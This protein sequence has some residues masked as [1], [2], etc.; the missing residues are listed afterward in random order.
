MGINK[1]NAMQKRMDIVHSTSEPAQSATPYTANGQPL[2]SNGLRYGWDALGRLSS[3]TIQS[4]SAQ[5]QPATQA[6]YTYDHRGLRI[7][8]AITQEPSPARGTEQGRAGGLEPPAASPASG[9][10]LQATT[11]TAGESAGRSESTTGY[12]YNE[13]RQLIAELNA[14]GRITRQYVWLADMPIAVIDTPQGKDLAHSSSDGSS[15]TRTSVWTD[16]K[17]IALYWVQRFT[18]TQT[19]T[20]TYL[21]TNH[22]GAPVLATDQDGKPVWQASYAPFG[23]ASVKAVHTTHTQAP[24]TAF[25]LN[26]RLPGQYFDAESGLHYNDQRYYHPAQGSYLSPDPLGTPDG[27]NPYAYVAHNP[28]K[29]ID[30]LG[31]VLFAFDGTGNDE[32][33]PNTLSNVVRFRDAYNDGA[34][35][36]VT[37]VGTVHRDRE[38]GDIA[39]PLADAG[40]NTSGPERIDRMMTYFY[41]EARAADDNTFMNID[42][43]G[44]SRG[45]AQARD[46]A[47]LLNE[48]TDKNGRLTY[49]ATARNAAG[50]AIRFQGSQCVRFRFMG[51]WDTV[52]STNQSG[53]SYNLGIPASFAHVS[54]AVALNEYRSA[55]SAWDATRRNLGST[56]EPRHWGGFPLESIGVGSNTAERVRVERGF[57]GAHADIGGG[58]PGGENQLSFVPLSWMTAQAQQ[59][60]V[61]IGNPRDS[62]P[63]N[64][65]IIHDQSNALRVGDP[66]ANGGRFAV[67]NGRSTTTYTVEDRRVNGAASGTTG[68]GLGFTDFAPNDRSMTHGDSQRYISYLPRNLQGQDNSAATWA[69]NGPRQINGGTN[70]TGTVDINGY[71][72]WLRANGYCFAGDACSQPKK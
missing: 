62:I 26:L 65:P 34:A 50:Q 51:L 10:G 55:D 30:P 70:Q 14:A 27:P 31:L 57:I 44:F 43:I 35:R 38:W 11:R 52:L 29:Y 18:S 53:T 68:R 48:L 69:S 22:L 58:Y 47:N 8:K 32:S 7:G 39:V 37:G 41:E 9:S 25:T 15:T 45:A 17:T 42:I 71:M 12:L 49:D 36:Y 64:N 61:N 72:A 20:L 66:L 60:G 67:R 1:Q 6:T 21:H 23:A 19:E 5:T 56:F 2:A 28:L 63:A 13:Q 24:R 40:L 33:N 46:F 4:N 3:L 54:H 16:L 59:A